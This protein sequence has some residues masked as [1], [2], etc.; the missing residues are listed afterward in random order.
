MTSSSEIPKK[1]TFA[2]GTSIDLQVP[3]KKSKSMPKVV[4]QEPSM[5]PIPEKSKKRV[6]KKVTKEVL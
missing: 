5:K 4:A 3:N 6:S 2:E 1:F